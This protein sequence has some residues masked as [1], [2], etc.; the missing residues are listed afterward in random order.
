MALADRAAGAWAAVP[1][2]GEDLGA[3]EAVAVV[4]AAEADKAARMATGAALTMAAM[5]VSATGVGN[6][7]G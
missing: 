5:R 7:K 1:A 4:E 2:E 6:N 3:A